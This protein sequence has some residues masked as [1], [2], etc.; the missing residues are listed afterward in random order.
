MRKGDVNLDGKVNKT[1]AD[2]V[3]SYSA[4]NDE[5]ILLEMADMNDDNE[6]DHMDAALI[7]RHAD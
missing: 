2:L 5:D 6:I 7:I 1:D 4:G 3:L